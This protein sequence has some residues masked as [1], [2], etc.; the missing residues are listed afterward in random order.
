MAGTPNT[1]DDSEAWRRLHRIVD[2]H[3]EMSGMSKYI[4][5]IL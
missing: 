3:Q 2:R 5:K 4:N 1:Y